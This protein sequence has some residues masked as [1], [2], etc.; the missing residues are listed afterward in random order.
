MLLGR[1]PLPHGR[2]GEPPEP[3][4][5]LGP[6]EP[7]GVPG[8]RHAEGRLPQRLAQFRDDL[9]GRVAEPVEDAQQPG[10]D[11]LADDPRDGRPVPREA[12][13]VVAFDARQVQALRDRGEH[14]LRRLRA[15]LAFEPRVVVHGHVAQRRDLLAA[16]ARGPAPRAPRQPHV[17]RLQRLAPRPE[18]PGQSGAVDQSV[19]P[20]SAPVYRPRPS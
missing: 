1:V 17:L 12:E 13:Q 8:Q 15:A 9:G 5:P 19:L 6:G 18:E 20:A 16:Q 3:Q 11:V 14:L 7:R 10:A 4:A 2:D